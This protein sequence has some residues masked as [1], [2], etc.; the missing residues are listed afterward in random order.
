MTKTSL[1]KILN[2]YISVFMSVT[3]ILFSVFA[4]YSIK[5]AS[6]KN[7]ET[8]LND[9]LVTISKSVAEP[10]FT[11]NDK[12][13][14]SL[15]SSFNNRLDKS[16]S[17]VEILDGEGK[18]YA[19]VTNTYHS[20]DS[21]SRKSDIE[22]ENKKIGQINV[23]Y[24]LNFLEDTLSTLL[25]RFVVY[26]FLAVILFNLLF[27]F[28]LKKLLTNPLK[29]LLLSL[30]RLSREDYRAIDDSN[31]EYEF[32]FIVEEFNKSLEV[33]KQRDDLIKKYMQELEKDVLLK[34]QERDEQTEK[35]QNS[36]R[37]AAVGEMSAGITH[38]IFNPLSVISMLSDSVVKNLSKDESTQIQ[39]IEKL[40]KIKSMVARIIKISDSVKRLSRDGGK[41]EFVV[42]KLTDLIEAIKD[43]TLYKMRSND[44]EFQIIQ[45]NSSNFLYGQEIQ[46]SQVI[47]NLLNNA[48]DAI[49]KNESKWIKLEILEK[50]D[51]LEFSI[52]DSGKGIPKEIRDKMMSPFFTTKEKGKGT[53]L[54]LSI[55]KEIIK[56]H[57]GDLIYDESSKNTKFIFTVKKA[58]E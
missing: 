13:L 53:G 33:I 49:S 47:I 31:F 46:L 28:L 58:K 57:G 4:Y 27:H 48:V 56:E 38:E 24:N 2:Y 32:K 6:Y 20:Q 50:D 26:T 42:F 17:K 45:N 52:T 34:T 1:S 3:L 43:L 8:N 36:A 35:A 7:F 55:A 54:G 12:T 30:L 21:L 25:S 44:V 51:F 23:Y 15:I 29:R 18:V 14:K 19:E 39:N 41:E 40:N 22:F 5:V 9:N 10:L 11:F 16:I 37:L